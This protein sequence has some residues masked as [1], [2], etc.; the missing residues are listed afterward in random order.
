MELAVPCQMEHIPRT[1]VT[2]AV[3]VTSL[4]FTPGRTAVLEADC[5]VIVSAVVY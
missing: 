1:E 3:S 2:V 5:F 4:R